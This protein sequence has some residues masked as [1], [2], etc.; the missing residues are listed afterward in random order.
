MSKLSLR[1]IATCLMAYV[2]LGHALDRSM[3]NTGMQSLLDGDYAVAYCIWRPLAEQG[4]ASSQ[5]H[6]GWLYANGNGLNVDVVAAV[7][8]WQRAARQGHADAQFAVALAYTTG[9]GMDR[10]MD[11]AISWYISAAQQG[12]EDSKEILLRLSG[13]QEFDL[14]KSH[15]ELLEADWYGW[16][17]VITK[18]R[19]NA[20]AGK[21]TKYR[22]VQKLDKGKMVKIIG[23]SGQ[24]YQ[25]SLPAD[26]GAKL[27]KTAWIYAPLI[28]KL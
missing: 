11:Q 21:G 22:I 20:R 2:S 18:G 3:F 16:P 12:H 9:E 1:I 14:I 24:W 26:E 13:D 7:D 10:D 25:I 17:G 27:K 19:V 4:D 28:K 15:P 5:Y 6:I 23:Q 8:W